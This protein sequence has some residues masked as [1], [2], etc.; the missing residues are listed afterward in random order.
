MV[1]GLSVT[2]VWCRL[3]EASGLDSTAVE[4]LERQGFGASTGLSLL[5]VPGDGSERTPPLLGVEGD[6]PGL[7]GWVSFGLGARG[8]LCMPEGENQKI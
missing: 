4:S 3:F 8:G 2:D 5:G 1:R 6:S 7:W